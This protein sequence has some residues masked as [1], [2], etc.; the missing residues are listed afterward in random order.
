M[1]S[2]V[3]KIV[4]G[5]RTQGAR[6]L[7]RAPFNEIA[8]PRLGVTQ[9]IRDVIVAV[10][11]RFASNRGL[12]NAWAQRCLQFIYDLSVAPITFD[13]ASYLAAAEVERRLR[14]LDGINVIFIL[15]TH[16]GAR[17]ELPDY[18]AA[19]DA[20]ARLSRFRNILVPMLAFLPSV[21]SY[22]VCG[23][24]EQAAALIVNDSAAIYPTDY[25]LFLPRHPTKRVI[26]ERARAGVPIWPMFR[27][28]DSGRR[29]VAAFLE[30]E[31]R[32]RRPVVISLR[33]YGFSPERN[34]RNEDWIGF[35]DQ[36][37]P[38][39]YAPIFVHDTETAM[40]SPPADFGRHI[41][42]QAAT[43]NLE[44]R[45]ALYEA[46]W[47]NMALM[48]GPMEL[49]WYN[50]RARYVLFIATDTAHVNTH[51][52]LIE[53]GHRIG[54]DLDFAKPDQRIVWQR[55]DLDVLRRSF[56]DMES[57]LLTQ[58]RPALAGEKTEPK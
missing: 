43:W 53:N 57:I 27:T 7:V 23:D 32:G 10:G 40:R 11:D 14:G 30:R 44:I 39:L 34:S 8:Y 25:R 3:G 12:K 26:H 15:G 42:C 6:Y 37:D 9:K 21:R 13:F 20:T 49:C 28:T 36:L 22:A 5:L 31:A 46:A 2:I 29:F 58:P 35:A 18:E 50:E 16:Q 38:A 52:A 1:S 4:Y 19:V 24:R 41:C 55:D 51:A 45:M 33:N 56:S 48:H 17:E 54:T 47:L